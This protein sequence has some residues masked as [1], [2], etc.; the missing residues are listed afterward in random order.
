MSIFGI[1]DS[2]LKIVTN[3]LALCFDAAQT[4]SYPRTGT[5]WTDRASNIA[6]TI[7]GA[8]TYYTGNGG[9]FADFADNNTTF[10][11]PTSYSLLNLQGLTMQAVGYFDRTQREGVNFFTSTNSGGSDFRLLPNGIVSDGGSRNAFITQPVSAWYFLSCTRDVPSLSLTA[12]INDG[13][14]TTNTYGSLSTVS[15]TDAYMNSRNRTSGVVMLDAR[16]SV[17]LVY[18]RTLTSDEEIQNFRALRLR[19]GI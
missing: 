2:N 3:G 4:V 13:A 11:L 6:C 15:I 14:R 7:G 8:F 9:Y 19:Y 18:S 5:S 16:F 1:R 10:Q 12:R 17:V